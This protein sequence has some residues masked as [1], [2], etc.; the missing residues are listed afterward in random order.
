VTRRTER[1]DDGRVRAVVQPRLELPRGEPAGLAGGD[2]PIKGAVVETGE[3]RV[4]D[5]VEPL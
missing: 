2:A 4:R 1:E 3:F 5:A